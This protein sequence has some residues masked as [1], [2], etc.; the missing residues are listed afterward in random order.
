MITFCSRDPKT[1]SKL[2]IRWWGTTDGSN[3]NPIVN[4]IV[5]WGL[6]LMKSSSLADNEA[7][8]DTICIPPM[9]KNVDGCSR[10]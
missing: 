5:P 1:S 3:M 4:K 7:G 8:D 2:F 9:F 10:G 6:E